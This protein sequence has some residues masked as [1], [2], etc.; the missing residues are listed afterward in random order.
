MFHDRDRPERDRAGAPNGDARDFPM[1]G[2]GRLPSC[3]E[4]GD[5]G[6]SSTRAKPVLGKLVDT[7]A[8]AAACEQQLHF[9]VPDGTIFAMGDNR[10]NS[11][12]SR[13]WGAVSLDAIKGRAIGIWL[14]DGKSGL[15]WS[16][17]G[18]LD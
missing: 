4:T 3:G 16:R 6:T 14:A 5:F 18:P 11:N 17:V 10:N 1:R 13:V 8:D 12:D 15:D 7:K 9:V 2:L